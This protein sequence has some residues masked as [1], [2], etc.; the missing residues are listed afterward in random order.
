MSRKSKIRDQEAVHFVTFT[1]IQWLD[2]FIRPE[3][4]DVFL[5]SIRYCQRYKGL[6]VYAYCIMSSHIHMIIARHGKQE[7]QDVIRDIKKYTSSKIIEAVNNNPQVSSRELLMWLFEKAG[8]YNPH[9][10]RYQFWQQ[11]S[12]PIELNT[13][14]KL[15]QRLDYIHNNPVVAGLVRYL[16]HYLFTAVRETT[17]SCRKICWR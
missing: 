3:Y 17:L 16:E 1:V 4:R 15:N 10:E 13:N 9:N 12:H 2:I 6:E 11:H 8:T 7:L 5:E 14:E